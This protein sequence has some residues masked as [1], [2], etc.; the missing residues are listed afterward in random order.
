MPF[1][2]ILA[3]TTRMLLLLLAAPLASATAK[4]DI[5]TGRLRLTFTERSPLSS[6]ESVR[7]RY[8]DYRP[9]FRDGWVRFFKYDLLSESFDVYVPGTYK[10]DVPH[11]LFVW[12]GVSKVPDQWF[13]VL[14]RR[15][16]IYLKPNQ[17]TP[18][19]LLTGLYLD[20]V[21]NMRKRYNIDD[22]RIFASGFSAGGH[23]AF[24]LIT[25]FPEVFSGGL[26]LMGD[27]NLGYFLQK[28]VSGVPTI[29][30][31]DTG[32]VQVTS[33]GWHGDVG[34]IKKEVR[35]VT[36]RG[37]HDTAFTPQMGRI[38]YEALLVDGFEHVSLLVAANH[39][40]VPPNAA[41]LDKGI[42][43]L[44]NAKSHT[45]PTTA[46]T[47]DPN[48]QPGQIA[49]AKRLLLAAQFCVSNKAWDHDARPYLR[50]IL[51]EYPTTPAATKAR[52]ML[53]DWVRPRKKSSRPAP[54]DSRR[55]PL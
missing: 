39:G 7:A 27:A 37:Q 17:R 33:A 52:V 44:A 11:G 54:R 47:K 6:E 3:Q 8:N 53:Q 32:A 12:F 45:A 21:H 50:Q 22:S 48:P 28:N 25:L 20:G 49:M 10:P 38:L 14:A 26:F 9:E 31:S 40:H 24:S 43:A 35:L 46:P 1:E 30:S 29:L 42:D 55:Q 51:D 2:Q 18:A 23:N 19:P 4:E 13:E 34:R 16:L 36:M 5:A 15:K 41:W